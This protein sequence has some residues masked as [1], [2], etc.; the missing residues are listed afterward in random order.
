MA[1][2]A[3]KG[4]TFVNKS[5]PTQLPKGKLYSKPSSHRGIL[6]QQIVAHPAPKRETSVNKTWL[7]E[8]NPCSTNCRPPAPTEKMQVKQVVAHS[9]PKG[10]TLIAKCGPYSKL[11]QEVLVQPAPNKNMYVYNSWLTQLPQGKLSAPN[12]GPP[13]SKNENAC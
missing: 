2:A 6:N 10:E 1:Q 3:H 7:P 12:R 4:L 5:W 8:G 13:N 11:S 9:A